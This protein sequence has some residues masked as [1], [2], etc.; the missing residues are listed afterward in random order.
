M[1]RFEL[2]DGDKSEISISLFSS[3]SFSQIDG[4]C[5]FSDLGFTILFI[6]NLLQS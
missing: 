2:K 4:R 3:L 6:L 1:T 5:F